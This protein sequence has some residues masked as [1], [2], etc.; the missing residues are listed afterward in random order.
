MKQLRDWLDQCENE[1][2][3]CG[4]RQH[5]HPSFFPDRLI[6][7]GDSGSSHLRIVSRK[8][9]PHEAKYVTLSHCWGSL[10]AG[11]PFVL[12]ETNISNF[13]EEI[14]L[15][16]LPKTFA[17]ACTVARAI[18]VQYIWID[19]LCIYFYRTI[20]KDLGILKFAPQFSEGF[21][22]TYLAS[23]IWQYILS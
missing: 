15:Q 11:R 23:Q 5:F 10:K 17:H 3:A 9:I 4:Q 13:M 21:N 22:F 2:P 16:E 12:L 6:S 8:D 1:H 18:G 7:V 19:S 20:M 14:P